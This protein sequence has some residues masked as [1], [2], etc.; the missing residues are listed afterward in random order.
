[1]ERGAIEPEPSDYDDLLQKLE[2]AQESDV[3]EQA[4]AAARQHLGMDAAYITSID[5]RNQTIQAIL[6]EPEVAERY[7]DSVIPIEQTYC[8]RMLNGDIPNVVPDTRAQPA[9]HDLAATR[10]IGSYVGVPVRLSDGRVHGTLCA[11]SHDAQDGIG[12]DELRFMQTLAGI[13]ATRLERARGD[14]ARLTERFRRARKVQAGLP[15]EYAEAVR[16][17]NA[18][19]QS[20]I[21]ER[22][23]GAAR[24]RLGMDAAYIAT[25]DSRKQTIEIMIGT[26]NAEAL[27]EGA[28]IPVDQTYCARMLT[29]EIPNIVVDVAAEPALRKVTVI[30]DIG[31]Y[32]GVPVKLA[33][34]RVHGSL[35]CASNDPRP[36]L[37]EPELHFMYVLADIVAA[38][39]ERAQGSMVRLTN[40]LAAPRR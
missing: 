9:L 11:V 4:L 29:G 21:V 5:S 39:I 6:G 35:C 7:Q 3:V 34:G 15:P 18:A 17:I 27:V 32:I 28:V 23:L 26:T 2:A 8:M 40:R 14:L 24:E 33:D 38:Q 10:E 37:G 1:V 16:Q 36:E 31:A 20:D 12:A 22:A 13:V 19:K 30:R 25:V